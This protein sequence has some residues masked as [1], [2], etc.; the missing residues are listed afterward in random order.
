MFAHVSKSSVLI[1]ISTYSRDMRTSTI[2]FSVLA[3]EDTILRVMTDRSVKRERV[4]RNNIIFNQLNTILHDLE[5]SLLPLNLSLGSKVAW[6]IQIPS[7]VSILRFSICAL[8]V[9]ISRW[10]FYNKWQVIWSPRYIR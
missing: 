3:N 7:P 5:S 6:I 2:V 1:P 8:Y 9:I 10:S 4:K